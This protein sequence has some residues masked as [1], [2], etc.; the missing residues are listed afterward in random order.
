MKILGRIGPVA[1]LMTLGACASIGADSDI[2]MMRNTETKGTAFTRAL[3][4]EYREITLFEKDKM[5]DWPDAG[6]FARK[7][8]R[9]ANGE[10]VEPEQIGD[11]NLPPDGV[12]ELTSARA[13]LVALLDKTARSKAPEKAARAQGR[14]DCW[15]EQKEENHQ[16]KHIAACREAFWQAIE[17]IKVAMAPPPPA[18]MPQPPAAEAPEPLVEAPEPLVLYFAFDS[19]ELTSDS[20]MA[21]ERTLEMIPKMGATS[22]SVTGHTDRAGSAEYNMALSLRR[23]NAVSAALVAKGVIA[24]G[25]SVA[26][27]GE[28][29]LAVATNDD[30]P[31]PA[32]R[33]VEIIL[34]Q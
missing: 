9:A 26:G 30:V 1:A 33:R 6:R 16:P 12:G 27:R 4:E 3:A 25:I 21:V 31:E 32:N 28:E 7:G 23:A 10:V 14:F 24:D 19:N 17:D 18:P 34:L 22:V 20:M 15:I 2:E 5:Y 11:W 8:L 13:Q 29:E